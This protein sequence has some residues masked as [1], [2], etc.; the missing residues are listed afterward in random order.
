[1]A[2]STITSP[3]GPPPQQY[4]NAE[5]LI[6]SQPNI[7]TVMLFL[8]GLLLTEGYDYTRSGGLVTMLATVPGPVAVFTARLF[9]L[10]K[11]L[12]GATPL[13]Y[14]APWS[15]PVTGAFDDVS[16][17]YRILFGPTIFGAADGVN[18]TFTWGVV[19]SKVSIWRNGLL[20][21]N[22]VDVGVGATAMVFMPGV[23]LAPGDLI[24]MQGY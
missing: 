16:T 14:V 12:G 20:Q 5:T 9:I 18:R 15:F 13:R 7:V 11:Q 21:T 22:N 19:L 10:G 8:N 3:P 17:D 1:M 23:E 6:N 4:T 24:T 2:I